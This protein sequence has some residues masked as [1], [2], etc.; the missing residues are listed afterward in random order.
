M[1]V[2]KCYKDYETELMEVKVDTI[3]MDETVHKTVTR[4]G[5]KSLK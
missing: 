4:P 2:F 3:V 5:W 1:L